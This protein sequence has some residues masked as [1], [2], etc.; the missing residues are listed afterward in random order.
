MQSSRDAWLKHLTSPDAPQRLGDN[1]AIVAAP[2]STEFKASWIPQG[3]A[4]YSTEANALTDIPTFFPDTIAL[5]NDA[6]TGGPVWT[7]GNAFSP[8][9][10]AG[11]I[12]CC[13]PFSLSCIQTAPFGI[14]LM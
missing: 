12:S 4:R 8:R 11:E 7:K 1:L 3:I 10:R 14:P 5:L 6:H 13:R 2:D 9:A